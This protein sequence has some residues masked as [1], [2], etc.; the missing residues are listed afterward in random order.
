MTAEEKANIIRQVYYNEDGFGPITETYRKAHNILNSITVAN[1]KEF[2][3]KQKGRQV[4][5][6]R[7]YNS[8]VAPEP[9]HELQI[10]LA[11]FTDSASDN[12]G[13]KYAFVAIDVFTKYMWVVA[14]KDKQPA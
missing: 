7:G 10:D 13:F 4:Q 12:S 8:Y 1:V 2:L 5:D 6:Y 9:L 3:E 14:I 11:T